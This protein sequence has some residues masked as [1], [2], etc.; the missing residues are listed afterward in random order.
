[1]DL[2]GPAAMRKAVALLTMTRTRGFV[3]QK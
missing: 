2:A 1:L 3:A